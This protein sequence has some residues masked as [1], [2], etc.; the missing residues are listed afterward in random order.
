MKLEVVVERRNGAQASNQKP[1]NVC[2]SCRA[3]LGLAACRASLFQGR[4]RA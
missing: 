2:R 3:V 4:L 1:T